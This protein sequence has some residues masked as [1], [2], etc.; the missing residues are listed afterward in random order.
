MA[1]NPD[2]L[3]ALE[4]EANAQRQRA[5]GA[6]Q[7]EA[8]WLSAFSDAQRPYGEPWVAGCSRQGNAK[9]SPS[10][11]C[12]WYRKLRRWE[13]LEREL[14]RRVLQGASARS[15]GDLGIQAQRAAGGWGRRAGFLT[16]PGCKTCCGVG[17]ALRAT[18]TAVQ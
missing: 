18:K 11:Q 12:S 3:R 13:V 8:P 17:I 16:L 14:R 10:P 6:R 1:T 4:E 15:R 5:H 9:S 7:P 2:P